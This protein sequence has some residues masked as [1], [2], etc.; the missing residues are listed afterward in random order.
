MHTCM[1]YM[2]MSLHTP[3]SAVAFLGSSVQGKEDST[4]AY[5]CKG[6]ARRAVSGLRG[7]EHG[8]VWGLRA[9]CPESLN[10]QRSCFIDWRRLRPLSGLHLLHAPRDYVLGVYG[11]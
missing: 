7:T 10:P 8:S 4:P 5:L 11:V 2:H 3:N 6:L 1:N 9:A